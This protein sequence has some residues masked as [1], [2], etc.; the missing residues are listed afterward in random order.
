MCGRIVGPIRKGRQTIL[1]ALAYAGPSI[2]EGLLNIGDQFVAQR[3]KGG[4]I[5]PPHAQSIS[6]I[7]TG[8]GLGN[9]PRTE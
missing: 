8:L 7:C 3:L 5:L 1:K 2:V 4:I 6:G 9:K